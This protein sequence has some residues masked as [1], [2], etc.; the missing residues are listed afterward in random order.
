MRLLVA[1]KAANN[2]VTSKT[3][4]VGSGTDVALPVSEMLEMFTPSPFVKIKIFEVIDGLI[5]K[6]LTSNDRLLTGKKDKLIC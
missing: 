5:N 6:S 2:P 1:P 3:S 4:I